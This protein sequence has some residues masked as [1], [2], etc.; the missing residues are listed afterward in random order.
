MV[1]K[2]HRAFGVYG[3]IEKQGQLVVIK[4][5]GGPYINRYDLPGGSLEMGESLT[6][7]VDREI[8][9]ETGLLV[10]HKRQIGT[11]SFT[12]PWQYQDYV[13][14]QHIAVFYKIE[15]VSGL[16]KEAVKQFEGQDALGAECIP[17][18]ALTDMNASPL[19]IKA[20]EYLL[21]R[22]FDDR[23]QVI[24]SWQVL[25]HHSAVFKR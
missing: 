16:L 24:A 14:N 18:V 3:I 13:L 15:E 6:K 17:L 1:K 20:K 8:A 7:A 5:N 11:T 12:Y 19:V 9:E 10:K 4:K 22:Q 25:D 23:D 21:G 2:V